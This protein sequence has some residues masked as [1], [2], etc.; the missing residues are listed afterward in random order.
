MSGSDS[1]E[2]DWSVGWFEPH[3]KNFTDD[4][5]ESFAVLMPCY[6]SPSPEPISSRG[7]SLKEEPKPPAWTSMLANLA[8]RSSNGA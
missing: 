1:D 5:E 2:S 6:G 8:R 7:S 3:S 4:E